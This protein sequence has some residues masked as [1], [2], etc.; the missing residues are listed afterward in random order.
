MRDCL[1][2]DPLARRCYVLETNLKNKKSKIKKKPQT[3]NG[4]RK[5]SMALGE[6]A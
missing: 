6:N 2:R 1:G 3:P 4:K 5:K